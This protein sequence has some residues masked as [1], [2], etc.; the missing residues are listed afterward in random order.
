[1][2]NIPFETI[3]WETIPKVEY[4]GEK[5]TSI[6][7]TIQFEGLRIRMVEYKEDYLADHWCKKGHILHC[8]QGKFTTQLENG[9]KIILREG[10]S[11]V[12]S[13]NLSSHLSISEN[14]AKLLII[15]GEFLRNQLD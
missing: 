4:P 14:G 9:E 13:D 8:L 5:G 3:N 10:M 2:T 11:F 12:V 6:W 7:Q 1:M 15:D